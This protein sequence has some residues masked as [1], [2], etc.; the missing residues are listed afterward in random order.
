MSLKTLSKSDATI[1]DALDRLID[2]R[3]TREEYE[4]IVMMFKQI[5]D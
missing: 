5:Q 4:R 1:N 3:I 2:G